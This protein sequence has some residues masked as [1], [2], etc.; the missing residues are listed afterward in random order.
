[1]EESKVELIRDI[2]NEWDPI[3]LFP[4]APKDEYEIEIVQI[5][6]LLNGEDLS[7]EGIEEGIEMIFTKAF[8]KDLFDSFTSKCK[9]REV[10]EKLHQI[11]QNS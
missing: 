10:A 11:V 1:M 6:N 9:C 4:M 5:Y 7:I 3:C 8:G 2:I